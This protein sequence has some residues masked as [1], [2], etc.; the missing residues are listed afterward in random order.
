MDVG[1]LNSGNHGLDG[2]RKRRRGGSPTAD[3]FLRKARDRRAHMD[4]NFRLTFLLSIRPTFQTRPPAAYIA[5]V[6]LVVDAEFPA[7]C[8][9]LVEDDEE[10]DAESNG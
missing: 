6:R 1:E 9:F 7:E 10:V 8:W 3:Q 5:A 2:I 4:L